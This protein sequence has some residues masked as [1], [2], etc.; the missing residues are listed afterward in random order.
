[1]PPPDKMMELSLDLRE[2]FLEAGRLF[3]VQLEDEPA[4][5][6]NGDS[7]DDSSPFTLYFEGSIPSAR[8]H[9]C[10]VAFLP[11][12]GVAPTTPPLYRGFARIVP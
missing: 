4:A 9:G 6:V 12:G 10:H 5:A 7:D 1:M 2:R 8:L 11:V 3:V